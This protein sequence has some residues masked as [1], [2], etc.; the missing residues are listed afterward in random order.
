MRPHLIT[1]TILWV[2]LTAVGEFLA[3]QDIL[4][5]VGSAEATD[6]DHIFRILMVMGTPVFTFVIA[7]VT[8]SILGFW[9]KGTPGEDGPAMHGHGAVPRI[10]L[11]ITGGLT[12]LVMIYP[13]LTGLAK[14][15]S[16][17]SGYG[18]GDEDAEMV[19]KVTGQRYSWFIEYTAENIALTPGP[20]KEMVLPV[21]TVIKFDGTS[22]DVIHS[23]WV[24]AF[25]M[26]IDVI[27]GKVTHM[28]V[29]PTV[30]GEFST[31]EAFRLQCSQLC[32][33]D[34]SLMKMPIRVVSREEFKA[35]V[36]EHSKG[37]G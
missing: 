3:L 20:G 28:T 26:R 23:M 11:G 21:D 32:G 35:W 13:G 34:H 17:R 31:E 5:V 24:P 1:A 15:Q 9:T 16:D 30:L 25:R 6:F 37:G 12:V 22:V 10:W 4:P 2:A 14:L 27:P 7:V 19:I 29:K 8:Y 18:W 33:T 36:A